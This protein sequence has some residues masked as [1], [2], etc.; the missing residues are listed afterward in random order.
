MIQSS[1]PEEGSENCEA[2]GS[3]EGVPANGG[4]YVVIEAWPEDAEGSGVSPVGF[5][6]PEK[7]AKMSSDAKPIT[8]V[9][10]SVVLFFL[11][12]FFFSSFCVP[13]F[14]D[15]FDC[16]FRSV[17]LCCGLHFQCA[18]QRLISGRLHM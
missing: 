5:A 2:I 17:R 18:M 9:I 15:C 12:F 11:C 8:N 1:S 4:E 6:H 16:D 3:D 13:F 10:I 7:K 14:R